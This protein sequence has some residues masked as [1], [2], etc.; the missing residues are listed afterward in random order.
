MRSAVIPHSEDLT[1]CVD[2]TLVAKKWVQKSE[3]FSRYPSD[4]Q[5]QQFSKQ[6]TP[7]VRIAQ[8]AQGKLNKHLDRYSSLRILVETSSVPQETDGLLPPGHYLLQGM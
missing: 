3:A 1:P 6:G 2:A 4:Q 8:G 7:C 5:R